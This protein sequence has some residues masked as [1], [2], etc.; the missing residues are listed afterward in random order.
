MSKFVPY[1]PVLLVEPI[2][3]VNM[4]AGGLY[5]PDQ[6]VE[7]PTKGKVREVGV[8]SPKAFV[9]DQVVVFRQYAGVEWDFDNEKL[10]ILPIDQVLGW[11]K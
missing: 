7:K 5:K 1:G 6:S 8:G 11:E 9:V 4:T 3:A 2:E 10:L